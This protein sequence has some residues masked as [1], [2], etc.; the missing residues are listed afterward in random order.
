MTPF[1]GYEQLL[2]L[3]TDR[4]ELLSV[5]ALLRSRLPEVTGGSYAEAAKNCGSLGLD[6]E[7]FIFA[8]AVFEELGLIALEGDRLKMFRGKRTELAA[9]K[10]YSAVLRLQREEV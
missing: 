8:L 10:I 2:R 4:S 3:P 1:C 5:F 7:T 9:S 6:A